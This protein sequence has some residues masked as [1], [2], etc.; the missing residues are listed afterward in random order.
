MGNAVLHPHIV[1][2]YANQLPSIPS[3]KVGSL[4]KGTP[5]IIQ[6]MRGL[7]VIRTRIVGLTAVPKVATM[8]TK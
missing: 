4:P 1:T 7:E 5:F 6:M 3:P 2:I 8:R